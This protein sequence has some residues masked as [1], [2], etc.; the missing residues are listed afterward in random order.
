MNEGGTFSFLKGLN[1]NKILS[2]ANKTLNFANKA[3]PMVKDIKPTFNNLKNVFSI[4]GA[5]N[6]EDKPKVDEIKASRPIPIKNKKT[7]TIVNSNRSN[8]DTL[9]FFQ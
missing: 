2:G 8:N 7:S 3:L 9:R 6:E 5:V 1:L 4:F